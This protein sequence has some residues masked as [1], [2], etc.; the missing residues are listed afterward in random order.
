[1]HALFLTNIQCMVHR[2]N[3]VVQPFLVFIWWHGLKTCS[4][5]YFIFSKS[6]KMQFKVYQISPDHQNKREQLQYK[7]LML[8]YVESNETCTRIIPP[9]ANKNCTWFQ[10]NNPS[11]NKL[12]LVLWC[13][14]AYS[15]VLLNAYVGYNS[16]PHQIC[17]VVRC[18]CM[19]FIL[20]ISICKPNL[21]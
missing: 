20:T 19:W 21:F 13:S 2:T 1:M 6:Y 12:K 11:N 18:L 8:K 4:N 16:F 14:S 17:L 3:M 7:N 5:F 10:N 9:F 15:F